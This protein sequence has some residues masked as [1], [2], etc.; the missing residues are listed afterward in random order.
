M[1]KN[2]EIDL[3]KVRN[4][5]S[6]IITLILLLLFAIA[7]FY[8]IIVGNEYFQPK[9]VNNVPNTPTWEKNLQKQEP[10]LLKTI[11][12]LQTKLEQPQAIEENPIVIAKTPEGIGAYRNYLY[13][14]NELII[15][16]FEE[17]DY[18]VQINYLQTKELPIEIT[19]ILLNMKLY[20]T[21]Y[22]QRNDEIVRVFP[23]Q[24]SWLE[25]LI[26]IEKKS[27]NTIHKEKLK[28]EIIA[29][30]KLLTEY[31]YSEKFQQKFVE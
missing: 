19:K 13:N 31:C 7:I 5:K 15:R 1:T 4:H 23:M 9:I 22:I 10:E 8:L 11:V 25:Q 30:L 20:S 24:G 29:S 28:E 18:I 6:I 21:N 3:K 17:R 16:F 2:I 12:P 27:D 26:K 14:L